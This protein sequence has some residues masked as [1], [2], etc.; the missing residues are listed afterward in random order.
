MQF[1]RSIREK[2]DENV[3]RIADTQLE[4]QGLLEYSLEEG[5]PSLLAVHP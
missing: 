3:G 1:K 5:V 2:R 4:A